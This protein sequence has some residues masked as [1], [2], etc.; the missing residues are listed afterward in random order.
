MKLF[1]WFFGLFKKKEEK[2]EYRTFDEWKKLGFVVMR[3]EKSHKKIDGVAVFSR[4]QVTVKR[5]HYKTNKLEKEDLLLDE[6]AY[7]H[8]G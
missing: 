5:Y 8:H 7:K 3:G 4:N 2:E 1:N 6:V